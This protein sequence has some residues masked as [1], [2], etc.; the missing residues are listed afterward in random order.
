MCVSIATIVVRVIALLLYYHTRRTPSKILAPGIPPKIIV[1][2][3]KRPT[4]EF[5]KQNKAKSAMWSQ[6]THR[7]T[8]EGRRNEKGFCA[9]LSLSQ[10][11][12]ILQTFSFSQTTRRRPLGLGRS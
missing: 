5:A 8:E 7:M 6:F 9:S 3:R 12:A 2:P 4:C 11:T 10:P 1:P